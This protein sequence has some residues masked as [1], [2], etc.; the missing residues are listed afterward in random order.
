MR[1]GWYSTRRR[2]DKYDS[3]VFTSPLL[4]TLKYAILIPDY[5]LLNLCHLFIRWC[6]EIFGNKINKLTHTYITG[7]SD[8]DLT[9]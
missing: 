2:A 9:F 5:L 8:Q 4:Q 6:Q 7:F 1:R 3:D